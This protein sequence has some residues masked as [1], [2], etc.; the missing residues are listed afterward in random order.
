[1]IKYY[2]MINSTFSRKSVPSL[3]RGSAPLPRPKVSAQPLS[4]DLPFDLQSRHSRLKSRP[5]SAD[6][7]RGSAP[8]S[9]DLPKGRPLSA[10]LWSIVFSYSKGEEAKYLV[11]NVVPKEKVYEWW[12]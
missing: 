2:S 4:G 7:P 8:L 6:L 3:S 10:D 11:E 5:L 1:M 12:D 9:G